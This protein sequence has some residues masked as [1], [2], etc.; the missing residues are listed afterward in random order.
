MNVYNQDY[1][2]IPNLT[3][4]ILNIQFVKQKKINY[5]LITLDKILEYV[6]DLFM[7]IS[8]QIFPI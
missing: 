4:Y 5:I 2:V 6:R 8:N 7:L 1:D 3:D